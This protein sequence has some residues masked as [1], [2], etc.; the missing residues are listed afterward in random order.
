[1]AA[2]AIART[3][4]NAALV[5]REVFVFTAFIASQYPLSLRSLGHFICGTPRQD[6]RAMQE[7]VSY[8]HNKVN[9][10]IQVNARTFG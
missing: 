6:E 1:M 5:A 9:Q 7:Q 8:L 2:S 3:L 4:A 10:L